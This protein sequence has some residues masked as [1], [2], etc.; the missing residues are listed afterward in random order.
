MSL[1]NLNLVN[2]L[3]VESRR[4]FAGTYREIAGLKTKAPRTLFSLFLPF[5]L[6]FMGEFYPTPKTAGGEQPRTERRAAA[7]TVSASSNG[8][9]CPGSQLNLAASGAGGAAPY[10]YQW[11][12]PSG[13][14]SSAQNPTRANASSAHSGAYG[15]TVTDNNGATATSSVEVLVLN[16]NY[17][18]VCNDE[19][20]I[21]MD[22]D[23]STT[24]TPDQ[25]LEGDVPDA[26]FDISLFTPNG[27]N[28]GNVITIGHLNVRLTARVTNKCTGAYCTT[29]VVP[30]DN[31]PP[32]MNC[33]DVFL[34]C[35]IRD[36][37]PQYLKNTL[38]L[39]EAYPAV[40]ENCGQ[41]T[42]TYQD[43]W[44]D[45]GCEGQVNGHENISGYLRR[46]WL[47]KDPAGNQSTCTQYL[48]AT[49]LRIQDLTLPAS[50]NLPCDMYSSNPTMSGAPSFKAFGKSFP[51]YPGETFCELL[52]EYKD[53]LSR[54]CEGT[55]SIIRT[56]KIYDLCQPTSNTEPKNPVEHIQYINIEDKNGPVVKCPKD[57]T[58][59]TD[60]LG[61][62]ATVDLPDV[63]VED[64]CGLVR[65][66][67][68]SIFSI[69]QNTGASN[70]SFVNG[71]TSNFPGNN[72][73]DKDTLAVLG[74][75]EC[76]KTG[77]HEV[78][79]IFEDACGNTTTCRF[80]ITVIDHVPPVAACQKIT[81]VALGLDGMALVEAEKLNSGSYDNCGPVY[82]KARRLEADSCQRNDRFH[83][84]IKF[85][86][87][88]VDDTIAVVLRVYD[89][90]VPEGEVSLEFEEEHSNECSIE[91]YV[92]DKLRPVCAPPPHLTVSCQDFDP[93]LWA[94]GKAEASDN[95]CLDTILTTVNKNQFDSLCHRGTIVRTFRAIDC[96]KQ[97]N[98]CTQ[99]IVVTYDPE[100]YV[101]FPDDVNLTVCNSSGDFGKPE[102]FG[103]QCDLL[104]VSHED[105]V[106]ELV[107]DACMK[108]ERTWTIINWCNYNPNG[109]CVEIP[110]PSPNLQTNHASN[111]KGPIVSPQ[112]TPAPWAPTV[113]K[114]SPI[115]EQ[116]TDYSK[117]WRANANCYVYKQI[118]KVT[119]KE[120]PVAECPKV[121]VEACDETANNPQL[122]NETHWQ[123]K[124]TKLNDLCEA[125]AEICITATDACS[126]AY[127]NIR[128]LLF[129]DLDGDGVME[130]GI[131]SANLPPAN[132]VYYGNAASA[133]LSGGVARGFDR[134]PVDALQKYGFAIQTSV[135]GS[136]KTACVRWNTTA[137]PNE[138]V[139]VELPYGTHKIKWIISDGC[140]NETVCEY[141][142]V[143]KD[144]KAPTILCRNGLS[145]P[146]MSNGNTLEIATDFFVQNAGDNCTPP[147]QLTFG[148]RKAGKGTGFPVDGQGKPV[149]KLSFD[150]DELGVQEVEV[151][152]KDHAGNADFCQTYVLIQDNSGVCGKSAG[153]ASISGELRTEG[154]QG[155]EEAYVQLNG[156]PTNG[157]PPVSMLYKTDQNGIYMFSYALP[158]S[159]S[160]TVAPTKEDNPLNG[161]ST[162]DLVLMSKHILGLELLST[163]CK[164][165]AADVNKSG[166]ITS[167]D[168]VE[169]RKLILGIYKELPNNNSWRFLDRDYVFP[170]PTNP[171][172]HQFPESKSVA[173]LRNSSSADDFTGIK[174]GDLNANA[175]AN[176]LQAIEERA[177]GTL[178]FDVEERTVTAGERFEIVL[179]AEESM[180]GYQ[181]SLLYEGLELVD[182]LP[183]G[184]MRIDNF[185]VFAKESTLTTSFD[186]SETATGNRP[187]F[188]LKFRAK[189][190]GKL[191]ELLKISSLITKAEAYDQDDSRFDIALRFNGQYGSVVN[192]VGFELYQN[193]PNPFAN[194]TLIGFH[195]PESSKAIL[196]VFDGAGKLV[197]REENDFLKGYNRFT[198]DLSD[199]TGLP[200]TGPLYY[201]VETPVGTATKMMIQTK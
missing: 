124:T 135:S 121:P 51:L 80:T 37:S 53:N 140:G 87:T 30:M 174:I 78:T 26:L 138:F 193:Q 1:D 159:S 52:V 43:T 97:S 119:D 88:D 133:N 108:I 116:A 122:W 168:I 94:Y 162:F 56:W 83:D 47:A 11:G 13:F 188:A 107:P 118:I 92:E 35:A 139:P 23:C 41:P 158:I 185:A 178:H 180:L 173:D 145:T 75:T 161:V 129:L 14:G 95:C 31:L 103:K 120:K 74:K 27:K 24:L 2:K 19:V 183:G 196:T 165:I 141:P 130:T 8:P 164:M 112:G 177:A 46:V 91:V 65:D 195:L 176:S 137:K 123:D 71:K 154:E 70:T 102:F 200:A 85:C 10:T 84:R 5:Y 17:E 111:L 125:P 179:K 197:H 33:K 151:W 86:C 143:V 146:V 132:T 201:K 34:P 175:V 198:L 181:F 106:F 134:R 105:K 25:V 59:T 126:G 199:K 148:V 187:E 189:R 28:I 190:S 163:P 172:A 6:F 18:L 157:T 194:K 192:N 54:Q 50:V 101:K 64:G 12:G 73:A 60:L 57:I 42:L 21:A 44:I 62:C 113:V 22:D 150:C 149:T 82:F 128:Y 166:S 184:D 55:F 9:V 142:I 170:D 182:I 3:Q 68:A 66:V 131:N 144:C 186:Q 171:F 49:R 104:A 117:F 61:C 191:S 76:L 155:L 40:A 96:H 100:F 36:Y 72:L 81:Q 136:K 89:V 127:L 110:N 58:V 29:T 156:T 99:R 7:L 38:G 69:D 67:K 4:F 90:P 169:L 109:D 147:N 115:D 93:S 20:T 114:V 160:Y 39:T 77:E 153:K 63:I 152:A 16:P 32:Q 48:Y 79:Y 45:V 98:Q 167:S 15:V